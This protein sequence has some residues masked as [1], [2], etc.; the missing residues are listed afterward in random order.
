MEGEGVNYRDIAKASIMQGEGLRLRAY[1]DSLGLLTI[2]YGRLIDEGGG[3]ST[4][5]AETMLQ[6]D[7]A[8]DE[9]TARSFFPTF[10]ALSD[11]RKAVLLD[12]AHNL[13]NRLSGF[14]QFRSAVAAGD[15]AKAA[16]HMV[17]SLWAK[18]VG[19]RAQRLAKLMREG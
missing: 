3:I 15:Y 16:E 1:K 2:G 8:Q 12:M 4:A 19:Q 10:E 18:Q 17:D 6:N 5:E 11:N 14:A 9:A 13:R 7:L